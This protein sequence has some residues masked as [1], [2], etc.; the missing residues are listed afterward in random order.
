[1][2]FVSNGRLLY[3][4][5]FIIKIGGR[6]VEID[7]TN[8]ERFSDCLKSFNPVHSPYRSDLYSQSALLFLLSLL[9]SSALPQ[10]DEILLQRWLEIW[11]FS[12]ERIQTFVWKLESVSKMRKLR[13]FVSILHHYGWRF[14]PIC[15]RRGWARLTWPALISCKAWC[16][17]MAH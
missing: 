11:V 10:K 6:K 4:I 8:Q 3:Q 12:S 16:T 14:S 1:M 15:S 13:K 7:T 5:C 17:A 2:A 9:C